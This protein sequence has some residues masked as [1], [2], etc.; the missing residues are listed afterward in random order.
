VAADQLEAEIEDLY[1]RIE[2]PDDWAEGLRQAIADEV[3]THHED[4]T[5]ERK[6][7][8]NQ[9]ERLDAERFKLMEAYYANAIDVTMLRREQERIGAELHAVES[10]QAVIES[11]LDNWQEVMNLALRFST[12]CARAYRRASD[13]TRKLFNAAVLDQVHVRDGHLVE[14]GYKEPFDLLFS[15][16]KFEYGDLVGGRGLEPPTSAV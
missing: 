8:A 14:A 13:R 11:S 2:V 6:L 12:S 9:H 4:T 3:A 15:V 7:L 10:R 16:P 5:A 1:G